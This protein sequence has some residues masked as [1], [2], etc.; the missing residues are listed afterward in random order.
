MKQSIGIQSNWL[1]TAILNLLAGTIKELLTN[2]GSVRVI[3]RRVLTNT[4]LAGQ[5]IKAGQD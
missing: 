1:S 3:Y 2:D 5:R 4:V